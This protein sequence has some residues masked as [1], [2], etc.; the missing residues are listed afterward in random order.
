MTNSSATSPSRARVA[1]NAGPRPAPETRSGAETIMP[2]GCPGELGGREPGLSLVL[3]AEGVDPRALC[4]RHRQVGSDRVKHAGESHRLT[5]LNAERHH[6]FDLEVDH[7]ADAHAVAD[8]V[9]DHLDGSS[10]DPEHLAHERGEPRHRATQLAAEDLD[11]L[12]ELFVGRSL[13][14]EHAEPPVPL[15]HD[16]RCVCNGG[17]LETADVGALDLSLTD[18]EDE[19]H[20]TEVVGGAVVE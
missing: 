3:D 8:A 15:G 6:V 9:V 2:S 14:D 11:Q 13:I 7:V 16:L 20:A 10:L 18:V 5:G 19:S 12:V 17:N 1:A 4:L